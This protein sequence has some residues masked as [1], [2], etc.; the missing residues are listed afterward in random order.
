MITPKQLLDKFREEDAK[1]SNGALFTLREVER[2][3]TAPTTEDAPRACFFCSD[4]DCYNECLDTE[5]EDEGNY[6]VWSDGRKTP[7]E[8]EELLQYIAEN[9]QQEDEEECDHKY[10][11]RAGSGYSERVCAKCG[12]L[13]HTAEDVCA[14]CGGRGWIGRPPH[15]ALYDTN[16]QQQQREANP[17]TCPR[18]TTAKGDRKTMEMLVKGL[19]YITQQEDK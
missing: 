1:Y 16:W 5:P 11:T 10:V 2:I 14:E 15:V 7:I 3:I 18:C 13:A 8:N 6:I 9:I 4:P 17:T 19:E 12:E